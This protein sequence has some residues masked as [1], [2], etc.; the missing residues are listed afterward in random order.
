MHQNNIVNITEGVDF[1]KHVRHHDGIMRNNGAV[2]Q[3]PSRRDVATLWVPVV[4]P[5]DIE[6]VGA[7]TV[8]PITVH[9]SVEDADFLE[10]YAAYRNYLADARGEKLKARK[11]RKSMAESFLT[12]QVRA[13]RSS[14]AAMTAE[15]GDLPPKKSPDAEKYAKR[16][17][18]YLKKKR[19]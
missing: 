16:A 18:D 14:L 6:D 3:L 4:D 8:V 2:V 17:A 5:D 12:H 10:R 7:G 19:Q 13:I 11:S 15:L 1:R 9:L